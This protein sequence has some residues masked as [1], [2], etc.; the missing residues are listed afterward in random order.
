MNLR[1]AIALSGLVIANGCTIGKSGKDLTVASSPSGA[2]IS[3]K[4]P[5]ST[6][7]GELVAMGDNGMVVLSGAQLRFLPYALISSM[8]VSEFGPEYAVSSASPLSAQKRDRLRLIS[9]F[10][11]GMTPVIERAFLARLTQTAVDTVR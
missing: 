9:R 8:T 10:P 4:V 7:T 2:R 11:Q 1:A 5:Q 6:V 3:A